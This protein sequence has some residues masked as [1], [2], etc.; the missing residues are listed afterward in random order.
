MEKSASLS[1]SPFS[2]YLDMNKRYIVK[3][4][5]FKLAQD[6]PLSSTLWMYGGPK[7]SDEKAIKASAHGNSLSIDSLLSSLTLVYK[8]ELKSTIQLQNACVEGL[9]VPMVKLPLPPS[10]PPPS[11][12]AHLPS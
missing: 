6:F 5:F 10:P 2:V 4:I 9:N 11:F 12:T 7:R 3:G 1:M 8:I